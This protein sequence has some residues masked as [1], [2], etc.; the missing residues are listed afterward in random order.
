MSPTPK[1][2]ESKEDFVSRAIHHLVEKEGKSQKAAV[3]QA[4]GMF[5][6]AHPRKSNP[7]NKLRATKRHSRKRNNR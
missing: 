4:Y 2:G 3:G 1:P 5:H 6:D 7:T